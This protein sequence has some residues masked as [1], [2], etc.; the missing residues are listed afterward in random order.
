M[1]TDTSTEHARDQLDHAA[2]KGDHATW[3]EDHQEAAALIES[4]VQIEICESAMK[5]KGVE[6]TELLPGV[7]LVIGAF[8][9]LIDLATAGVRLHQVRI[10]RPKQHLI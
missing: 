8:P 5:Q 1:N 4:G 10:V 9:R 7:K 6:A 3:A 2:W